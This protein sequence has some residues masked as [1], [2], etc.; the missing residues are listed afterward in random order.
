M[1]GGR[2]SNKNLPDPFKYIKRNTQRMGK[3]VV[4]KGDH[5]IK[6][7]ERVINRCMSLI[8]IGWVIYPI[9]TFLISPSR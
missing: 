8:S 5:A 4:G 3:S 7:G 2:N 9:N 1:G 6:R